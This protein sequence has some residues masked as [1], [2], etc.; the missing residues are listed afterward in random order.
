MIEDAEKS[1]KLKKA[2]S[3]LNLHR[4]IPVSD[5]KWLLPLKV[6]R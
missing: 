2:A 5:G 3:S 6:I 1:G 4:E